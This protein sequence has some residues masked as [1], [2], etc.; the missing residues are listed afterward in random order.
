[1]KRPFVW[2]VCGLMS[3]I[4]SAA[5]LNKACFAAVTLTVAAGSVFMGVKRRT[6]EGFFVPLF[7]VL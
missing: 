7:C 6:G 1:M 5:Y 2:F 3:G 4:L